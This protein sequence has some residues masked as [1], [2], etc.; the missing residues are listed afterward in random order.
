M[1]RVALV[2]LGPIGHE[3]AR[4]GTLNN[5]FQN[6][7]THTLSVRLPLYLLTELHASLHPF[8][9]GGPTTKKVLQP[10]KSRKSRSCSPPMKLD[11]KINIPRHKRAQSLKIQLRMTDSTHIEGHD[12]PRQK[13]LKE[14]TE[15]KRKG[16]DRKVNPEPQNNQR[17]IPRT[18]SPSSHPGS[19]P[20]HE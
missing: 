6:N 18:S 3:P 15:K 14:K 16:R 5:A 13:V 10:K 7:V 8:C 19:A 1:H 12:K 11:T 17:N 4:A 9:K 2:Q 20:W